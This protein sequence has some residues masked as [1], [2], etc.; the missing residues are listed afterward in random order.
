MGDILFNHKFA[1]VSVNTIGCFTKQWAVT[2]N[3]LSLFINKKKV[4]FRA[5]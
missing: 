4:L 1:E 3:K 2:A 5:L